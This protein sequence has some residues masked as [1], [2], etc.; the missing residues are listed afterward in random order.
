MTLQ[1]PLDDIVGQT[2]YIDGAPW[3]VAYNKALRRFALKRLAP[4]I[5]LE[6]A[7]E[8]IASG[9][10]LWN[11]PEQF[12]PLEPDAPVETVQRHVSLL[13][14]FRRSP[15]CAASTDWVLR[16]RIDARLVESRAWLAGR[17]LGS[18]DAA[19]EEGGGTDD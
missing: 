2:F 10:L 19:E 16:A 14:A 17:A 11:P 15:T 7:L 4:E 5:A 12:E 9:E 13:D 3:R 6:R 8:L 18:G 1:L